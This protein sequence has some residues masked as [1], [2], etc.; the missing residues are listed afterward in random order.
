[1]KKVVYV[2]KYLLIRFI[3]KLT[4]LDI[5]RGIIN[6][7]LINCLTLKQNFGKKHLRM[8]G[9]SNIFSTE[10]APALNARS[11]EKEDT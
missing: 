11:D 3:Q 6:S 5:I 8:R 7:I 10:F 2:G 1:M 4:N 9:I